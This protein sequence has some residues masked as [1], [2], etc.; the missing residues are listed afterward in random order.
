MKTAIVTMT[1][2]LAFAASVQ[3]LPGAGFYVM[4]DILVRH[5]PSEKQNGSAW[6]PMGGAPDLFLSISIVY[7]GDEE[8]H[9][10]ST[11]VKD[12]CGSSA[13]WS[14]SEEFFAGRGDYDSE[15]V[16]LLI[17]VWDEDMSRHDF[18]D[19]GRIPLSELDI[20]EVEF[21]L[22]FGTDVTFE[23]EGPFEN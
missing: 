19:S 1:L 21:E 23:L 14:R 6:D 11:S 3:A 5:A 8:E 2:L 15:D 9:Q 4:S 17:E 12:N 16:E 13:T 18:V 22:S 7:G 20:G 10:G